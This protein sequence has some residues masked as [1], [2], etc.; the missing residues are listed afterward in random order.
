MWIAVDVEGDG[1]TTGDVDAL[2]PPVLSGTQRH[3][4]QLTVLDN[5]M[6]GTVPGD[7]ICIGVQTIGRRPVKREVDGLAGLPPD[8]Q[9]ASD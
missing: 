9:W 3:V 2:R 8:D 1:V 5:G 6:V 7:G 4:G